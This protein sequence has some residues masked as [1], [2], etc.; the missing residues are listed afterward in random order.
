MVDNFD[1]V[2]LQLLLFL[3]PGADLLKPCLILR[4]FRYTVQKE[5]T[6]GSLPLLFA[7]L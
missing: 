7:L 2:F 6:T 5:L 3:H 4:D 1:E